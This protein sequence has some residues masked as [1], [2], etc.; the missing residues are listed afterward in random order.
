MEKRKVSGGERAGVHVSGGNRGDGGSVTDYSSSVKG[1][2][3]AELAAHSSGALSSSSVSVSL[4]HV[5]KVHVSS[6]LLLNCFKP[7]RI[8]IQKIVCLHCYCQHHRLPTNVINIRALSWG[9]NFQR[10][11]F[12][13]LKVL[14]AYLYAPTL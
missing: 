7:D 3:K 13:Y 12:K 5:M 14:E 8:H 10:Y 2:Q 9:L 1:R 6:P 4:S 11:L